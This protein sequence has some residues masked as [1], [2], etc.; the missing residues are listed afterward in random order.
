M[1]TRTKLLSI[2][3]VF[4]IGTSALSILPQQAKSATSGLIG[5]WKFDE[6]SGDIAHDSVGT[7][8]GI[9]RGVPV[10]TTG[11]IS[12]HELGGGALRFDGAQNNYVALSSQLDVTDA[13]T[14]EAWVYPEFDPTNPAAYPQ[15]FGDAGR[16]IVRKSSVH[17]DTFLIGFYS[18]YYFNHTNPVPYISAAFFYQ[19]GGDVGLEPVSIPGLISEGQWYHLVVTFKRNDYAR[20]YV[21]GVEKM[22]KPTE[23][24]PLRVSSTT[25]TIGQEADI[26]GGDPVDTPSTPQTWIGKIDEVKIYNSALTSDDVYNDYAG[27]EQSPFWM[28]WWFWTIIAL[29]AIVVVLAF[30]TVHYRKKPS[31]SKETSVVQSK[32]TQKA[33]KVCPK[34]GANLPA[35]S[36]FC[37][38]CGTS[39]E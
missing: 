32:T 7:N 26:V 20:L 8:N 15:Q 17:D 5:Y 23:D 39:L 33:N 3:I 9:I 16:Q 29:G 6:G 11:I 19:G 34:C 24:K 30:T 21:N 27:T 36:K 18:G 28:Q 4:L 1:K 25:L 12:A 14:V 13:M 22:S 35:D 2:A 38:K 10:W 31:V 37:G